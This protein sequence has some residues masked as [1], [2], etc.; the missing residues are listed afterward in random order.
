MPF[1]RR[2]E[3]VAAFRVMTLLEAAQARE[4][5]GRTSRPTISARSIA[6]CRSRRSELPRPGEWRGK[7]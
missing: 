6:R 5:A 3:S 7:R 1:A 2:L 4:A